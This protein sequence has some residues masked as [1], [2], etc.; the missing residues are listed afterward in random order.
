MLLRSVVSIAP[1]RKESAHDSEQVSQ[2]LLGEWLQTLRQEGPW[3]EVETEHGYRG[4]IRTEQVETQ[5]DVQLG[6]WLQGEPAIARLSTPRKRALFGQ[7]ILTPG[8]LLNRR[9]IPMGQEDHFQR[10]NTEP[11]L[12]P[13]SQYC[14]DW[15]G[16]PYLWGGRSAWGI[17]CSGLVQALLNQQGFSFPRDAWQQAEVGEAVAYDPENPWFTAGDLLYF[18]RPGK[19]V[20]HVA[21]S[22]GGTAYFHAS[23][24]TREND[25]DPSSSRYVADRRETL[26]SARRLRKAD[27]V[28][29]L[30]QI[31]T[32]AQPGKS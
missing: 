23:E 28:P 16:I 31:R 18:A 6:A 30:Q 20:H 2:V 22:L 15:V 27:L 11:E 4:W 19:R 25:L 14:G 12:Q 17:D 9:E 26:V 1:L 10:L 24:W 29:L 13:L 5:T 7:A 3:T 32:M 21:I 8:S